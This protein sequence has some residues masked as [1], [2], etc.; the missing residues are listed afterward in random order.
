MPLKISLLT[1]MFGNRKGAR[2]GG[3]W[4]R[5]IPVK[6]IRHLAAAKEL[7]AR[8]WRISASEVTG[9]GP[10]VIDKLTRRILR[11]KKKYYKEE[12]FFK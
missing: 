1:V 2:G 5:Q 8:N 10:G 6:K 11:L 9:W 3:N 7:E 4:F 12:D